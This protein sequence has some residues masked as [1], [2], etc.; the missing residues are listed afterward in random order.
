MAESRD[1]GRESRAFRSEEYRG[2]SET[3]KLRNDTEMQGIFF[4]STFSVLEFMSSR[5][6]SFP[7]LPMDIVGGFDGPHA[8]SDGGGTLDRLA[9]SEFELFPVADDDALH[10][11]QSL[12]LA[13][14]LGDEAVVVKA[15]FPFL[16]LHKGDGKVLGRGA[17]LSGLSNVEALLT[18]FGYV[19]ADL[20][21]LVFLV[22][23]LVEVIVKSRAICGDRISDRRRRR[24]CRLGEDL[25]GGMT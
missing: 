10:S 17:I 6:I 7:L 19:D 11:G 3:Q 25:Q 20:D 5:F 22:V 13:D 1:K 24:C 16:V 14:I 18:D 2:E 21:H 12:L 23:G 15:V 4:I 8:V 9:L